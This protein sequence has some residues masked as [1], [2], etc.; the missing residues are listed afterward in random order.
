MTRV[1]R[2]RLRLLRIFTIASSP[3]SLSGS[4]VY[5]TNSCQAPHHVGILALVG[6]EHTWWVAYVFFHPVIIMINFLVV[7]TG[8]FLVIAQSGTLKPHLIRYGP[9]QDGTC[10]ATWQ[11]CQMLAK[12]TETQGGVEGG[13]AHLGILLVAYKQF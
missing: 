1:P 12:G 8:I 7:S 3:D 11:G 5:E 2:A 13:S 4:L 6:G 9:L 10:P